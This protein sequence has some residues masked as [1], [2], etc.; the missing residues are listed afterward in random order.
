MNF[1]FFVHKIRLISFIAFLLSFNQIIEAHAGVGVEIRDGCDRYLAIGTWHSSVSEIQNTV[2]STNKGLYIDLNLDGNF[3]NC[4]NGSNSTEFFTFTDYTFPKKAVRWNQITSGSS[5]VK[6]LLD[7][8]N[9]SSVY[10]KSNIKDR[11]SAEVVWNPSCQNY[12]KSWLILKLPSSLKP[13]TIYKCRTSSTSVVEKPCSSA[14]FEIIFGT[15]IKITSN[16]KILCE[17]DSILLKTSS[18][19]DLEWFRNDTLIKGP[20]SDSSLTIH[21]PGN[22]TVRKGGTGCK[23]RTSEKLEILKTPKI[24]MGFDTLICLGDSI[25]LDGGEGISYLWSNGIKSRY[26]YNYGDSMH[27][28]RTDINGCV[29]I[30][31]FSVNFHPQP[32][33]YFS[34]D[35][36]LQCFRDHKIV[37]TNKSTLDQ[38]TFKK[39]LWTTDNTDYSN[40]DTITHTYLS[41]QDYT[42]HLSVESDKGCFDSISKDVTIFPMPKALF[43]ADTSNLC[44]RN[45]SFSIDYMGSISSGNFQ[46]IWSFGDGVSSST[47]EDTTK[48]YATHGSYPVRLELIS[49]FN[50]RDTF[51]QTLVVHPQPKAYFSIDD[52]LQCFR[53][54]KIVLT[55]KS[56]LDQGTFKKTLWTTDNTDYSNTDT[57]THTY[58]SPQDYTIHLSVESDKGCFDS[59][60]KDVTI[61]PMPK[62]LFTADTS[63]L[64]ER[65]NSFSIDYMGS[66][67][68]GNFQKIW[69]FGDGVSSSTAEDTTKIYATHGSYPV[70]LE[71]I[72][73]FNCRDTFEQTLVVHPQPK[74]YFSIDDS[75]QCFRDHKIVLTNKS[76]L[77]QGTFK[78]LS[79]RPIIRIIR[80]L[81]PLLTHIYLHKTTPFILVLNRIKVALIVFLKT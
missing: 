31:S 80:I 64:C 24:E 52:S 73:D 2:R 55:N 10:N 54:H 18:A 39:T 61:F 67:S 40:T 76:T 16:S 62:A 57:I 11:F 22:Y 28:T 6:D 51:E 9:N 36:S 38:G 30:D 79:G 3:K 49:D 34:I 44:E 1:R 5:T 66:I 35:D 69:S 50:C 72:S 32:K 53:D 13:G 75:L 42:I 4:C 12:L 45:N 14:I 26:V 20:S 37:L 77:D 56:T 23:S 25:L 74:A 71:L 8:F 65:N 58:L 7:F 41:P 81:I 33:A 60:S 48:I 63:N 29:S 43:T 46:K 47:A 27:I 70:R 68:S 78:K 17:N 19:N 21:K 59:I 15:D